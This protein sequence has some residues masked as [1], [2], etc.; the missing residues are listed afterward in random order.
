MSTSL[1]SRRA[2]RIVVACIA[3][4]AL[5]FLGANAWNVIDR[6]GS[7]AISTSN[8]RTP[9]AFSQGPPW[10]YGHANARFTLT[11]YADLECP[12]CKAYFPVLKSWIDSHPDTLLE[13][14]HLPLSIHEPAATE[15]AVLA[16]CAGEAGGQPAFWDATAWIY[17]HTRGNGRGLPPGVN[18][19]GITAAI[20]DCTSEDR[21][22]SVVHA[23]IQEAATRNI[24]A[25]P[26]VVLHDNETGKSLALPGP[27]DRDALLSAVDLIA[28]NG[29]AAPK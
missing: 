5:T 6:E 4:G 7:P 9:A 25:T 12:F 22:K 21:P 20:K 18:Y 15:L 13:W 23:Q 2:G 14:S 8:L 10:L 17:H 16:E 1:Y 26:T 19:P 11:L 28:T 29:I 27:V 24:D 3:V